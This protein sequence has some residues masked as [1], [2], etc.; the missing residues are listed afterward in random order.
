MTSPS[1]NITTPQ[2]PM[3][4]HFNRRPRKRVNSYQVRRML[5]ENITHKSTVVIN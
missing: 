2:P 1:R 5:A 3:P 4:M